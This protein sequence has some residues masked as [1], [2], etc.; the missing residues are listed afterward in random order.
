MARFGLTICR[1]CRA[2]VLRCLTEAETPL[3]VDAEPTTFGRL[4]V[5][6]E[7]LSGEPLAS[8]P[9]HR[10]RPATAVERMI[11]IPAFA[12][13]L[14]TVPLWSPH[15]QTCAARRAGRGPALAPEA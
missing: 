11:P 10:V 12:G 2:R 14:P 4:V 7:E 3:L 15:S 8:P 5:Y 1:R 6:T 9:L 13:H